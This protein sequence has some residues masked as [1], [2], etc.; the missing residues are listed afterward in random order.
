MQYVLYRFDS[1]KTFD[2]S[3][4][5]LGLVVSCLPLIALFALL[6]LDC[7]DLNLDC[8]SELF[9]ISPIFRFCVPLLLNVLYFFTF[10]ILIHLLSFSFCCFLT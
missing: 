2:S 6:T 5:K 7:F 1:A 4:F 9:C 3:G 8:I 10:G